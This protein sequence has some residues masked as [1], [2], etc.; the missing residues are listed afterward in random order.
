MSTL[1]DL[2]EPKY[3]VQGIILMIIG[4]I[5]TFFVPRDRP[6]IVTAGIILFCIHIIGFLALDAVLRA[7]YKEKR[8]PDTLKVVVVIFGPL[9]TGALFGFIVNFL[10]RT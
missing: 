6:V 7:N 10:F 1:V 8:Y 9:E 2:L 5:G 3:L 4:G